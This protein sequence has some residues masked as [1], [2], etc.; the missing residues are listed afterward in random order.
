MSWHPPVP[1]VIGDAGD[2]TRWTVARAWPDKTAGEYILEVR[3][4]GQPG[5]RAALLR[6]GRFEL[7]APSGDRQLPALAEVAP[8]GEVVVHRAH[9]RAVV[10]AGDRYIKVFR[11]DH[12]AEASA[13]HVRM[14]TILDPENFRVPE[15]L[16]FIPDGFAIA[17]LAGR[18]LFELG[19]DPDVSD[20]AVE[21]AWRN[22]S[23]AWVRQHARAVARGPGTAMEALPPRPAAVQV[24]ILQRMVDRWLLHAREIPAARVQRETVQAAALDVS[25]RLLDAAPDPLV[26]SHGDLH[27]KQIFAGAAGGPVGLLDFDE[28]GRAEAA[29]DIANLAVHLE[30]RRRQG[31]LTAQRYRAAHGHVIAAARE[32][33]VAPTRFAAYADATRLRLACLYAFRPQ[34]AFL[35]EDLLTVPGIGQETAEDWDAGVLQR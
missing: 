6:S 22:W 11:S 34:W 5:V 28:A 26:F 30:L 13:R 14:S 10:R 16:A 21:A 9:R 15:L 18:S 35:A 23:D 25:R 4:A 31:R 24:A 1:A 33:H 19:M 32:L 7:I 8:L 2:A 27:D 29:A 20:P 12:A 3:A 17:A